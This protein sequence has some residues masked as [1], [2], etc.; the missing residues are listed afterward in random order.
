M[1]ESCSGSVN[2]CSHLIP[3]HGARVRYSLATNVNTSPLPKY[4]GQNLGTDQVPNNKIA[5]E[6]RTKLPCTGTRNEHSL[7][8]PCYFSPCSAPEISLSSDGSNFEEFFY[9]DSV[10]QYRS[11]DE[12]TE[13]LLPD[14]Y[15][16]TNDSF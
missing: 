5:S 11:V 12:S 16:P 2:P 10:G 6:Y 7:T 14:T 8:Q 15:R 13:S 9:S 3:G 1:V 4:P